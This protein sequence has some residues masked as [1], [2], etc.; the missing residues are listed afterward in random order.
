HYFADF[1]SLLE[2]RD[3]RPEISLYASDEEHH[4]VVA[5]GL[6]LT[7]EAEVRK[8]TGLPET[9]T[10]EDFL[11]DDDANR[12]LHRLGGFEDAESILEHH[13]RLR[14]AMLSQVQNPTSLKMPSNVRIVGAINVD[15][16]THYL[17]PKVLD[18]IHV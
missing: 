11:K 2:I 1:L 8:R 12:L 7:I 6:F 4:T 17:S 13:A 14:R 16:T 9:A 3:M 10:I 18:R 15:E 5:H